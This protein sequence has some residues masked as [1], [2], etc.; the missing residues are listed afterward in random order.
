VVVGDR[1]RDVAAPDT[2]DALRA[3]AAGGD[4]EWAV[5]D[6]PRALADLAPAAKDAVVASADGDVAAILLVFR[7]LADDQRD[8]R[9]DVLAAFAGHAALATTNARLFAEVEESLRHQIDL[10]RQKDEFLASLS[11][12]LRT[13]L[14]SVLG[15]LVTLRQHGDELDAPKRE[16]L[17]E[18]GERQA[19]RLRRLIEDLLLVAAADAGVADTRSEDV[20]V[21]PLLTGVA[22]SPLH[23]CAPTVVVAPGTPASIRNDAARVR[24]VLD[25]LLDNA[26][27]FAPGPIELIAAASPHGL[28]LAV[29]DHGP[30]IPVEDRARVFE[31]FVQLDQSA[32]RQHG[33]TGIG[34]YLSSQLAT[35]LGGTLAI[36]DTPGGGATLVLTL[37]TGRPPAAFDP[38]GALSGS[39]SAQPVGAWSAS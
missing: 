7:E 28:S 36:E 37:G 33:G 24:Q 1:V 14:T 23:T 8:A 39:R 6:L 19:L 38:A 27:K 17:H 4:D 20:E 12:E 34:L 26:A 29:R 32:T 2:V 16:F 15:A 31:R 3:L 9:V 35:L 30:G 25:A 13:P 18:M 11:H 21:S 22:T 10:N 5:T